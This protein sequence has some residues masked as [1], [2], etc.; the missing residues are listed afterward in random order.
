VHASSPASRRAV[1]RCTESQSTTRNRVWFA[2]SGR[3][4]TLPAQGEADVGFDIGAT[5][6]ARPNID[7][8]GIGL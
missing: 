1:R 2:I 4:G 5:I 6:Q 3:A 8:F 7:I